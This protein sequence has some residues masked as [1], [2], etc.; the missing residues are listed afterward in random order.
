MN[1]LKY[2]L[3]GFLFALGPITPVLSQQVKIDITTLNSSSGLSQNSVQ[4]ILKDRYGFMWF[5]T[6]DGLNRYDGYKFVVY[7]H[8]HKRPGSLPANNINAL[9][10]DSDGNIWVGTRLGGLSKYNRAK[11]SFITFKHDSLDV[12]SI[13]ENTINVIYSDKRSNL[14]VGTTNGLNLY[15]KKTGTFKR[16][17]SN[18]KD[19]NSLDTSHLAFLLG[20][21]SLSVR[22]ISLQYGRL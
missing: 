14:W 5:G 18:D 1:I 21:D 2:I 19:T 7:K 17:F 11:D 4:C 10:E 15:D 12:H 20:V 22:A 9:C 13:S 16:F 8:L 3:F 6:Q